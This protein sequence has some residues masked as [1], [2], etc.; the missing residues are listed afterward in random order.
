MHHHPLRNP[1]RRNR[2]GL[3]AAT[4]AATLTCST[5]TSTPSVA[6]SAPTIAVR[7]DLP[8][9][10]D[11]SLSTAE[12]VADLL[13]RMT[14]S[15]K[16]GQMT[17]AERGDV[18]ADPTLVKTWGLGSVLS[19]GGSVPADNTPTGWADMVDSFQA[20]ALQTRLGIPLL[21]G[22]DSVHGHGNLKGCLLYTSPSPRDS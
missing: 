18:A 8:A 20:Q 11:A 22:V 12:R 10:Q 13:S 16:V 1:N 3:L 21:Y 14:L 6:T 19:G 15:E 5:L 17:Q 9:Y 7:V 4:A 2:L